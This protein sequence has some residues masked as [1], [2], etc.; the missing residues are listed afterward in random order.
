MKCDMPTTNHLWRQL[1]GRL[2]ERLLKRIIS[3]NK[4][5]NIIIKIYI[6]KPQTLPSQ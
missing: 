4:Q 3:E 2:R 5:E 1:L 6:H